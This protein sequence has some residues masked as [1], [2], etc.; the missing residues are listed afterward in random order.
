MIVL[1]QLG[2][3]IIGKILGRIPMA[4]KDKISRGRVDDH[5]EL[6]HRRVVR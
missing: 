5:A 1:L 3:W 4:L 2:Q 6:A